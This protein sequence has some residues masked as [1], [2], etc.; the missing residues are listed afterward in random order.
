MIQK[1]LSCRLGQEWAVGALRKSEIFANEAK[2][3]LTKGLTSPQSKIKFGEP[4]SAESNVGQLFE[5]GVGINMLAE[6]NKAMIT[7][8]RFTFRQPQKNK[9]T[10]RFGAPS[11][12]K[13]TEK[14]GI[15]RIFSLG[16]KEGSSE[17]YNL[18]SGAK[19][20]IDAAENLF[21]KETG[22]KLHIGNPTSLTDSEYGFTE[23]LHNL[24][25]WYKEGIMPS[26]IKHIVIGHGAGSSEKGSWVF[27]NDGP[28]EKVFEYIS[29]T[30]PKGEKAIVLTCEGGENTIAQ[31]GI[32]ASVITNLIY[33]SN[34]GKIVRSGD[35]K[36]IGH[37]FSPTKTH[38]GAT[39]YN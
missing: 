4:I 14:T 9:H 34:P 32:G 10:I 6:Q 28:G 33:G 19:P 15:S 20:N 38:S 36:I 30:I 12:S 18:L 27:W 39:Y 21:F 26:D 22:A 29:K 24:I 1:V 3:A 2:E 25:K 11:T 8:P 5:N 17:L 31:P 16:N 37:F 7:S 35:N 13:T 23:G